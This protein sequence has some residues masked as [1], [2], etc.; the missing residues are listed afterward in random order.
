MPLR[1]RVNQVHLSGDRRPLDG[2][3]S[4]PQSGL[5]K[6]P[7]Q[8]SNP[9][10]QSAA[11]TPADG[12]LLLP[13]IKFDQASHHLEPKTLFVRSLR[14]PTI[15][16]GRTPPGAFPPT[17]PSDASQSDPEKPSRPKSEA[18]SLSGSN[19]QPPNF[20]VRPPPVRP[21]HAPSN[22]PPTHTQSSRRPPI[23]P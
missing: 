16:P 15:R 6:P 4:L 19:K 20:S 23:C 2:S 18:L 11:L 21:N 1:R 22:Q 3:L 12:S 7:P 14:L 17:D 8:R 10:P 5:A 13:P 9:P